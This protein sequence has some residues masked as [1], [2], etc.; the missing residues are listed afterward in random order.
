[1]LVW[2]GMGFPQISPKI[3]A[4][5]HSPLTQAHQGSPTPSLPL[6]Q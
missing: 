1:M 4:T 2:Y 5:R 3:K 6:N